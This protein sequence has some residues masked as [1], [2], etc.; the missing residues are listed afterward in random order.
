MSGKQYNKVKAKD[1]EDNIKSI[2]EEIEETKD[3]LFLLI[4]ELKKLTE[5]KHIK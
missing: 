1:L 3:T 5:T 4:D 2:Y